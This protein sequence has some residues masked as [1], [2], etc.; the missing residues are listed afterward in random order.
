MEVKETSISLSSTKVEYKSIRRITIKL[1][2]L[3]RL[4][5]ELYVP[6]V[7]LILVKCD[8]QATIYIVKNPIFHERTKHVEID[9]HFVWEIL[10][11]R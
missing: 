7:T 4:L 8:S 3:L 6:K 11:E 5:N 9:C 2:W 10:Q 1:A